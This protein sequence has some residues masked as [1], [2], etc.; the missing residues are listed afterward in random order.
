MS[1]FASPSLFYKELMIIA[2]LVYLGTIRRMINVLLSFDA[3]DLERSSGFI[4][5]CSL[6]L[7]SFFFISFYRLRSLSY[8]S[9]LL[10]SGLSFFDY[11]APNYKSSSIFFYA[12]VFSSSINILNPVDSSIFALFPGCLNIG[13]YLAIFMAS[14]SL[15]K[16][17]IKSTKSL[18]YT[19]IIWRI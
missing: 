1:L 3:Y 17:T 14:S 18:S 4:V 7:T 15:L 5:Y 19:L 6:S 13:T 10:S 8:S 16:P 11:F 2:R 12:S 9:Y